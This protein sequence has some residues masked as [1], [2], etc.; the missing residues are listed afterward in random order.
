MAACGA[1]AAGRAGPAR[2]RTDGVRRKHPGGERL[3]LRVHARALGGRLDR[4]PQ[5]ADG[6]SLGRRCADRIADVCEG[7]GR[8]STR[9]NPLNRDSGTA[10][11]Q[12]ETRTIP[13]VF[14]FVADPV[15]S[16]FVAGLPRPGGNITGFIDIEAGMAGKWLE[17]LTEIAPG[18]KRVAIMFNPDTAP[19]AD[20]ISFPHSRRLPDHSKC[21]RSQRPFTAMPKSKRSSPPW[22]LE[23]GGGLVVMPDIFMQV[24]RA[25]IISQAARNNVPAIY[26]LSFIRSAKAVCFPTDPTSGHLS[27]RGTLCRSH[28][29]WCKGGRPAGSAANQIRIRRQP[30]DR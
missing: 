2:R 15:G 5:F 13:I 16:G 28:S 26:Q 1:G 18:V 29:P 22:A 25:T 9:R 7:V 19:V 27:A 30:Q 24:H 8:S 21:C 14:V 23:P 10:A 20:R 12:R 11:L 3:A 17:L 6:R 4:R